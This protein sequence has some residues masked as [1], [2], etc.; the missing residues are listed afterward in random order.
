MLRCSVHW[1]LKLRLNLRCGGNLWKTQTCLDLPT[2]QVSPIGLQE[3]RM[4]SKEFIP[5]F[6]VGIPPFSIIGITDHLQKEIQVSLSGLPQLSFILLRSVFNRHWSRRQ[7]LNLLLSSLFSDHPVQGLICC[8][9]MRL[10]SGV[11]IARLEDH[12]RW[13]RLKSRL[14]RNSST[15]IIF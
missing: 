11:A 13:C 5:S 6:I 8:L 12:W 1:K 2:L 9:L 15:K 4:S 10:C 7:L 14:L 3:I